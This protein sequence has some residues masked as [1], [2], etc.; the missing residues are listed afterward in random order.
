MRENYW[1]L[2]RERVKI[3]RRERKISKASSLILKGFP[4]VQGLSPQLYPF[5]H[6]LC[7]SCMHAKSLELCPTLCDPVDCS[8][9]GSSVHGV[10]QTRVLEWGA[11]SFSHV[12]NPMCK[13]VGSCS[14]I[15]GAQPTARW[16][17]RG[18]DVVGRAR[19]RGYR[20]TC[21]WWTLLYGR[22]QHN[23]VNQLSSNWK[24]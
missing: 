3:Y 9:P 16:R 23:I 21:G 1:S 5:L 7:C 12:C 13:I 20:D 4:T 24:I 22:N 15:P 14:I 18:W 2:K 10:S 11:I 6:H 8:P 19:E 17:P